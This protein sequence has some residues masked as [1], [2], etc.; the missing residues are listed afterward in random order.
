MSDPFNRIKSSES[1]LERTGLE[2]LLWGGTQAVRAFAVSTSVGC[3]VP[4]HHQQEAAR[5][6]GVNV[7][8]FW[9]VIP[10][11]PEEDPQDY[12]NRVMRSYLVEYFKK[13]V[14]A[15]A[16]K[17]FADG[18]VIKAENDS[19]QVKVDPFIEDI[20]IQGTDADSF[21]VDIFEQAEAF[22]VQGVLVQFSN[23]TSVLTLADQR[24]A[25]ARPYAT[26]ISSEDLI[27]WEFDSMRVAGEPTPGLASVRILRSKVV[28]EGFEEKFV[29]Q[30][31]EIRRDVINI[32]TKDSELIETMPNSLG[33]VPFIEC[34]LN[35]LS[36][37]QGVPPYRGLADLNNQHLNASSDS[38]NI[39]HYA[40]VPFLHL[41]SDDNDDDNENGFRLAGN[42]VWE[43][44]PQGKAEWVEIDGKAIEEGRKHLEMIEQNINTVGLD[45]LNFTER[46]TATGQKIDNVNNNAALLTLIP[47]MVDCIVSTMNTMMIL[48]SNESVKVS[49]ELNTDLNHVD[50]G[51][52]GKLIRELAVDKIISKKTATE[53][54]AIARILPENYDFDDDQKQVQDESMA[55]LK[56]M[57]MTPAG[58]DDIE[59]V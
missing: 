3:S 31:L 1:Q 34:N 42:T 47:L 22:A 33:F 46:T 48:D 20:D 7:S 4:E 17:V 40:Q 26:K 49:A 53:S 21:F 28:Y 9:S 37:M 19:D 2:R 25:G 35:R 8:Q 23:P 14:T 59:N 6:R 29:D 12:K 54:T 52:D 56:T 51:E 38:S 30:V 13:A 16:G 15:D 36:F 10:Q 39:L 45:L 44:G 27:G 18:V 58:I 32:Y 41:A 50:D 11:E 55:A 24:A 57:A 5:V 43:T